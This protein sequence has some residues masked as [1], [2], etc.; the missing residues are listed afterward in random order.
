MEGCDADHNFGVDNVEAMN[1]YFFRRVRHM[2]N[3][4]P[5]Q[6]DKLVDKGR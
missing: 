6:I 4:V 1:A 2:P 5:R 3:L